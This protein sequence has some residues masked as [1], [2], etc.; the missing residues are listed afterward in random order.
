[1]KKIHSFDEVF[2]SQ[3][4]FRL[5]LEATSNPGRIVDIKE[6]STKMF[7][8]K[9]LFLAVAMTLLDNETGFCAYE[10]KNLA[11]EIVSLTLAKNEALEK[12]DYIF[13]DEGEDG[14]DVVIENAKSGTLA[15]PQKSAT[16]IISIGS[17]KDTVLKIGGPGIK[18]TFEV[19]TS[20]MVSDAINIRDK[21]QYEYPCGIDFIFISEDGELFAV[22]RLIRKAG[23]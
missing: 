13:T 16:I 11:D 12:A 22:P 21:Q 15:D 6:F 5:I 4:M 19:H 8:E 17:K 10:N 9:P 3:R 23:E 20:E 2:D 18:D 7:G 14:L 1:M